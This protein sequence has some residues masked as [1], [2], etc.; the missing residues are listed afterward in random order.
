MSKLKELQRH[1]QSVW[2][3]FIKRSLM[4]SGELDRLI[5]EDGVRGLTSNP[6]I[7]EK[8][9]AEGS[10][11]ES[12]I[13]KLGKRSSSTKEIYEQLALSDIQAAAD[14]F[15]SVYVESQGR[16]GFVSLEV[17]PE[18]THD[19]D[20]T[21]AEAR[22]L[23]NAVGRENL[24]IKVPGTLEG[25]PAFETLIS[26]GINVNVTLLFSVALYEKVATAY[27]SGLAQRAARGGELNR[28]A[29]VASFFVSRV[30]AAVD[31]LLMAR[32]TQVS[33]DKQTEL[34][35]LLGKAAIANAKLAYGKYKTI[36]SGIE[37]DKLQAKGARSQRV[38]WASTGTK[39]PAYRDV[40][41]IEE[42][43]GQDT[44]NTI[45]P[46]TLDAFR[47]HG[48]VESSLDEGFADAESTFDALAKIGISMTEVT[49]QLLEE[50]QKQFVDA[51]RKLLGAVEKARQMPEH[52]AAL[53]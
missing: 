28:I 11:Y 2:L 53:Q 45:P 25:I 15:H 30:D 17:S 7:F 29:S 3:D 16:D 38:L 46:A 22:R 33:G 8:A 14:A 1:G 10:E 34:K 42:L 9:I 19:T 4:S 39:N 51:F 13:R 20:G 36:F 52:V 5:R 31:A 43:I 44:V 23:W 21:I 41:Y 35:A 6:S 27:L 40:V 48:S 37:W 26:E 12:D 24:M 50:G 18:L 32:I 49:Q 47:D